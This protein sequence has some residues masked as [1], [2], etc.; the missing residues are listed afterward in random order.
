M[1]LPRNCIATKGAG[2]GSS[3]AKAFVFAAS[4]MSM[5]LAW[6]GEVA[7]TVVNLSG[8]LMARK[9]D[10]SVKA[11]SLKS[12][13]ENGDTLVSEKDTYARIRF[14]DNSE[15]TLKPNTQFKIE[16]FSFDE[17]RPEK[18]A[19][20]FNL[21]KGGLRA[22]TGTLGKRSNERFG[23]NTPTATIGI[24]GT[25]FIAEYIPPNAAAVAAYGMASVAALNQASM[26]DIRGVGMT[27][28]D[29]PLNTV[30][31]QPI[32][33]LRIAQFNSPAGGTSPG[34]APGLYVQVLDGMIH[35]SNPAGAQ[36]FSAG[37]F[38]Y[39]PNFTTPPVIVPQNPGIKFTPPPIFS[40]DTQMSPGSSGTPPKNSDVDCEVR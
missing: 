13:V 11:L 19:A 15:I 28:T 5:A 37:Q 2:P 10:G 18:D 29:V 3:A 17:A 38:G 6:A 12:N 34:R 4:L 27:M 22:V 39:T 35:V 30:P 1:T 16:N 20:V 26:P 8:P 23:L 33:P 7:G 24:R 9:A 25:I 32:E 21:V 40:S 14:T 36:N 31:V